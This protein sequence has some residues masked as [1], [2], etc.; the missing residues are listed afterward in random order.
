MGNR[1]WRHAI[2]M[3]WRYW[4]G[5]GKTGGLGRHATS[6]VAGDP[7]KRRGTGPMGPAPQ[8]V[9]SQPGTDRTASEFPAES[10]GNSLAVLSVPGECLL[11]IRIDDDAAAGLVLLLGLL[12]LLGERF[13][14]PIVG[15]FDLPLVLFLGRSE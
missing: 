2:F 6:I 13:L 10:A 4:G 11:R 7:Q 15:D 1:I 12:F 9:S 5:F 8:E 14:D 3:T